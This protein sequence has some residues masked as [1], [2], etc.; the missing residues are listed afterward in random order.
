MV[1]KRLAHGKELRTAL[2]GKNP[3]P[4]KKPA[5]WRVSFVIRLWRARILLLLASKDTKNLL[6]RVLFI[7]SGLAVLVPGGE[8]ALTSCTGRPVGVVG[9]RLAV[10]VDDGLRHLLLASAKHM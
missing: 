1:G 5:S 3:K 10:Y 8:G 4:P 9:D 6:Q 2:R 7:F